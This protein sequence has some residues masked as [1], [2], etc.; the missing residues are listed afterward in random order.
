MN[1]QPSGNTISMLWDIWL[2]WRQGNIIFLKFSRPLSNS[3]IH[4]GWVLDLYRVRH[5]RRVWMEPT[6][7]NVVR[8]KVEKWSWAWFQCPSQWCNQISSIVNKKILG[9][10]QIGRFFFVNNCSSKY[11]ISESRSYRHFFIHNA[12]VISVAV[13]CT[14]NKSLL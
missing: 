1:R 11:R 5:F 10:F 14:D 2:N 13:K 9:K 4:T 6:F 7:W 8:V 12:L 3:C